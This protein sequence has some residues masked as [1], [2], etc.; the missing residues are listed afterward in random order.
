[1]FN[2]C[3]SF[4]SDLS[5]WNT[6][7]VTNM[8]Q[9]FINCSAF[10]SDLSGWNTSLVTNMSQMFYGCSSFNDPSIANWKFTNLTNFLN[11][12]T[13]T[14]YT[15]TQ[16]DTFLINLAGNNTVP[17]NLTL[18]NGSMTLTRTSASN[19]AYTTLTTAPKNMTITPDNITCFLKGTKIL[20]FD[21]LTQ[22][23]I[24]IPIQNLRKNDLI[25]TYKHGYIPLNM[26]GFSKVYNSGDNDR[27][28]D[29]LYKYIPDIYSDLIDELI[30]T[31]GH[32]ILVDEFKDNEK[33]ETIKIFK[34]PQIYMIDDKYKL[35][36]YLN[37]N[38]IPYE[39]EGFFKIYHIALDNEDD[40]AAYGIW[41]NGLLAE[42]CSKQYLKE[43][44]K[45][46]ITHF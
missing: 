19:S 41:A 43:E 22:I 30:I 9:M 12:I 4:N 18:A 15:D 39:K 42:S 11:F 38:A 17:N 14:G 10:N 26:I 40:Y 5:G 13:G 3:S 28:K 36:T 45:M 24:Y 44:S 21:Q 16:Y 23:E 33:E 31:G 25:K 37:F 20:C 1:M 2:G 35:L 6:S 34:Q 8:S 32:S 27:I 29:R 46:S 7:L